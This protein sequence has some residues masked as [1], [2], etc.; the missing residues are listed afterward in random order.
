MNEIQYGLMANAPKDGTKIHAWDREQECWVMIYRKGEHWR[1]NGGRVKRASRFACWV[2]MP[3][4]PGKHV[5]KEIEKM[6][7]KIC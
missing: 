3:A 2:P 6:E 5:L 7:N 4:A 1:G